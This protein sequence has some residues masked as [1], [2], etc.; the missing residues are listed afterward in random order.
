[1]KIAILIMLL[2]V[3]AKAND[4]ISNKIE[5]NENRI[6]KLRY[7]SLISSDKIFTKRIKQ[8][9]EEQVTLKMFQET[10]LQLELDNTIKNIKD[11]RTEIR[12]LQKDLIVEEVATR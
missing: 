7:A 8:I 2:T 3:S 10:K 11:L 4:I 5:V 9:N 6:A 1:M 12:A